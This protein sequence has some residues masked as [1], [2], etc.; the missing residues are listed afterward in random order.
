MTSPTYLECP[1][2][3]DDGAVSDRDGLFADGQSLI[4]GC[5]G[6]VSVDSETEPWIHTGDEPCP[7]CELLLPS[8]RTTEHGTT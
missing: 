1:C 5:P 6:W 4:C 8:R 2:C 7:R 3:G